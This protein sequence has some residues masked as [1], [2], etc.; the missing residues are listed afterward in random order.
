MAHAKELTDKKF[1]CQ[2]TASNQIRKE[3]R[4]DEKR[5]GL[6]LYLHLFRGG[7]QD[8]LLTGYM[9]DL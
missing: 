9:V 4:K 5:T 3:Y 1:V 2:R 6:C 8:Y 7:N